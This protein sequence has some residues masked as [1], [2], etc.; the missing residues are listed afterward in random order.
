MLEIADRATQATTRRQNFEQLVENE[1]RRRRGGA[2][3]DVVPLGK[4]KGVDPDTSRSILR[5]PG[6]Q[7]TQPDRRRPRI[8]H[9]RTQTYHYGD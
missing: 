6:A 3:G 7:V 9:Q 1:R 2:P 4:R 8:Y 5:K